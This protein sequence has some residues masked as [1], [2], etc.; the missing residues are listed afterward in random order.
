MHWGH[1][2]YIVPFA[3]ALSPIGTLV[4]VAVWDLD[5]RDTCA[6]IAAQVVGFVVLYGLSNGGE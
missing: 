2:L 5:F 3:L 4:G 6:L 1:W